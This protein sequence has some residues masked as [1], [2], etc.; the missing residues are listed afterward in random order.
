MLPRGPAK[1]GKP[2]M[3]LITLGVTFG[4]RATQLCGQNN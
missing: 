1:L 3:S 4:Q 2:A